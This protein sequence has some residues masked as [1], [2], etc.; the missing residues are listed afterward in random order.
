MRTAHG[1]AISAQMVARLQFTLSSASV[2]E[3]RLLRLLELVQR[4]LQSE[5][6]RVEIGGR[7]PDDERT[8]WCELP[9][10][11]RVVA[12]FESPPSDRAEKLEKLELLIDS[13]HSA[14]DRASETPPALSDVA[15][16]R[17]LDDE[18][19]NLA[20]RADAVCALVVDD[21]SPVLWG[22]SG[23]RQSALD[24]DAAIRSA[25]DLTVA[26][27]HGLDAKALAAIPQDSVV[28][29]L[30][31]K[32]VSN[33]AVRRLARLLERLRE[34]HHG[35]ANRVADDLLAC[36]AIAA[37]RQAHKEHPGHAHETR[38][39]ESF[40][41]VVRSFATIYLVALAYDGPFSQLKAEGALAHAMPVV[42]QLVLALPPV[43]PPPEGARVLK[44]PRP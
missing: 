44:F 17:R 31:Q 42:E 30:A 19:E 11:W 33:D 9:R 12:L 25:P 21:K 28:A 16:T 23:P 7:D 24:A 4:E 29:D 40:G 15:A 35:H 2:N 34:A 1:G 27:E 13:L 22:M 38:G 10:G 26:E 41:V 32:G 39:G 36:R 5:D 18:L 8:I 43:D 3:G 6:A 20:A 37:A 14:V